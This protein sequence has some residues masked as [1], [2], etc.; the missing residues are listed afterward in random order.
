MTFQRREPFLVLLFS[1]LS[2][3]IY[4]LY[5]IYQITKELGEY[6][7]NGNNPGL[8]LILCILCSPYTIYWM[9]KMGKQVEEAQFKSRK[10]NPTDNSV[11]YIILSIFG[12]GIVAA[13]IMQGTIN[14]INE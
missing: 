5:W 13:L 14:E 3:G 8:E 4:Y 2:C 12:L 7:Q 10:S 11:L 6:L 1:V 9:Y